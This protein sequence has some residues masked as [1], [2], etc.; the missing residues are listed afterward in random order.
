MRG[1]DDCLSQLKK[2]GK[3]V[4]GVYPWHGY[5]N[6]DSYS[7]FGAKNENGRNKIVLIEGRA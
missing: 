5:D 1:L 7:F 6:G 4:L 3:P 2:D